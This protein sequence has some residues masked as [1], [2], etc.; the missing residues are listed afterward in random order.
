MKVALLFLFVALLMLVVSFW[1]VCSRDLSLWQ[2]RNRGSTDNYDKIRETQ[3]GEEIDCDI[4]GE[5]TITCHKQADEVYLP[6]SFLQK[7]FEVYGKLTIYDGLERFEWTHSYS[8][9]FHPKGKYNPTGVFLYFENYNVEVRDRVKCVSGIEGVPISTQW[10]SQGYFY[11][12]QIA[13][14]GLSHYSKNLTEPEPKRKVIEDG[15]KEL[16]NWIVP[17]SC[18]YNRIFDERVDSRILKFA[19]A[20]SFSNSIRLK[21]DHVLDFV[22]SLDILLKANSS[23]A[24][25][26]QNRET[27][28]MYN[29]HYVASEVLLAAQVNI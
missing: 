6:F 1:M 17:P 4:N 12:T 11:P 2:R 21:M 19:T 27:K 18:V 20:E 16:A 8:R 13:Q 24:V 14:F 10:E 23:F 29:L 9:I 28:E 7:Y 15:E 26:L 22:M 3:N 25:V 5:Y